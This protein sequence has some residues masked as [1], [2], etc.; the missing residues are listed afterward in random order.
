MHCWHAEMHSHPSV[1]DFLA[2]VCRSLL[3]I[4]GSVYTTKGRFLLTSRSK[5]DARADEQTKWFLLTTKPRGASVSGHNHKQCVRVCVCVCV[6]SAVHLDSL[7]MWC[8]V[9][10]ATSQHQSLFLTH[11]CHC[12]CQV[13]PIHWHLGRSTLKLDINLPALFVPV[14]FS[15]KIE[16]SSWWYTTCQRKKAK[17]NRLP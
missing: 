1:A 12:S 17:I 13:H 4:R 16:N 9:L 11:L 6:H 7:M 8:W 15:K 5:W 2:W 14:S 3:V 10:S